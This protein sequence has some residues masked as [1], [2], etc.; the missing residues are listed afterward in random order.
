M[1]ATREQLQDWFKTAEGHRATHLIVACDTFDMN[2]CCYPI[3]VG[4]EDDV[5]A[6]E[7]ACGDRIMEIYKIELGWDAQ[8]GSTRVRNI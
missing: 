1:V 5:V 7:A 2:A 4:T 6:K 3:Y 8:S